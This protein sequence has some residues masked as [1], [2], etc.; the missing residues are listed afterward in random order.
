MV[1]VLL[2]DICGTVIAENG[3]EEEKIGGEG[4]LEA[5]DEKDKDEYVEQEGDGENAPFE[6][7]GMSIE[8]ENVE[9]GLGSKGIEKG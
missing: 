4:V 9:V 3:E 7:A 5:K 6:G 2:V 1:R 8:V